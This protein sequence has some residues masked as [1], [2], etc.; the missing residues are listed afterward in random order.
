MSL[1]GGYCVLGDVVPFHASDLDDAEEAFRVTVR[2]LIRTNL[3]DSLYSREVA[4]TNRI[5]VCITGIHEFAWDT[6]RCGFRTLLYPDFENYDSMVRDKF[7]DLSA[8]P[9]S[10]IRAAAFWS[11]IERFSRTG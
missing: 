11:T 5:G 8:H 1:L 4:R 10:G 9:D 3:M 2:A 6:F 7:G